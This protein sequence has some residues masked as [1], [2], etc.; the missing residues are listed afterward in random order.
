[1]LIVQMRDPT[2]IE[3]FVLAADHE[4]ASELFEQHLLA[5]GG[6]PDTLLYREVGLE[7]LEN[8]ACAAVREALELSREGLVT[9]DA[10]GCWAFLIPLGGHCPSPGAP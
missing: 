1:M 9:C 5:H 10:Q 6:D 4:R 8:D 7:H 3:A 2:P